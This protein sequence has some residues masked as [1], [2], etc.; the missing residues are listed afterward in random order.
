M[1]NK[2]FLKIKVIFLC[3]VIVILSIS[4]PLQAKDT[5]D[6]PQLTSLEAAALAYQKARKWDN[7]AILWY[8]NP[9]GR[10]LD[11]HWGENDLSW[12]WGFLFARPQDD[13]IYNIKIVN[14]QIVSTE[15]GGEYLKRESPILPDFPKDRPGIS[16][17][18]AAQTVFTAGA[19]SWERP[20]VVY[21]IDNSN[22]DFQGKP[23]WFF[24]FGSQLSTYTVDGITGELLAQDYFDPKTLKKISPEEV[25]YEFYPDKVAKIREENFIY[26]YFEAI[27]QGETDLYF[28]MMDEEL[29]G[30]ENK[31]EMWKTAFSGLDLIKVVSLYPEEER[32]WYDKQ[33]LYKVTIYTIPKPGSP[34]Y[35]WDEG[36]NTR[37]ITVT[38]NENSRKIVSIATG[39]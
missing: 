32:K 20:S 30:D 38:T 37:W 17:Q 1:M 5:R 9:Y 16:M 27:D 26:D 13:K 2:Y 14:N 36:E 21:I 31:R 6:T 28:S 18:E 34:Y 23:V 8:I 11:Y 24:L 39:P 22:K 4:L 10:K 7:E 35:G 25:K 15:E 12:E 29:A 19:P 3:F 33:P